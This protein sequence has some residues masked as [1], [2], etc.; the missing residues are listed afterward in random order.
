M[1][2]TSTTDQ[3]SKTTTKNSKKHEFEKARIPYLFL[4][5]IHHMVECKSGTCSFSPRP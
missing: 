3:R 1:M 5:Q 2:T 4:K